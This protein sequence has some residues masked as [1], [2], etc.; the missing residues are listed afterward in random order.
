MESA[1]VVTTTAPSEKSGKR[2]AGRVGIRNEVVVTILIGRNARLDPVPDEDEEWIKATILSKPSEKCSAEEE[3]NWKKDLMKCKISDEAIC[4]RTIMMD[5]INRHQLEDTL[6]YTCESEWKCPS[7][8]PNRNSKLASRMP[9]PKPDLAVAFQA[10]SILPF[11]QQAD[12]ENLRTIMCPE[13]SKEVRRDRAFHFLSMEVKGAPGE[14]AHLPAHRQ[15][16]NTATQ[17]LHNMYY[18]MSKAGPELLEAFYKKVRFYSIV[19]DGTFFHV[20][21][22]RAI[23]LKKGRIA[24]DYP[25]GFEYDVIHEQEGAYSKTKTTAIIK[26]ILIEY[27]VK[28]LRPLLQQTMEKIWEDRQMIHGQSTL[29]EEAEE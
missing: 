18:F 11:F 29:L 21:V 12:L 2:G 10:E 1:G 7:S 3:R 25:L 19:A 8:M 23:E 20:R 15:N 24:E 28:I 6:D 27:G 14:S 26:N 16:L 17:A 13:S 5:L 22:H 4:Q 9:H